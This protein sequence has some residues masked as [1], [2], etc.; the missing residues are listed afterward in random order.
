MLLPYLNKQIN[1][2]VEITTIFEK[3]EKQHIEEVLGKLNIK[4]KE[5]ILDINWL[6]SNKN[7]NEE[8]NKVIENEIKEETVMH[9]Q[10]IS[11]L[12]V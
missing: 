4:N 7:T 11:L 6:D 12:T 10:I 8:I 2:D 9:R 5:K 1:E 3:I